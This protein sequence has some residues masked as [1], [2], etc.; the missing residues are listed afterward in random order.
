MKAGDYLDYKNGTNILRMKIVKR[1]AAFATFKIQEI[2]EHG[3]VVKDQQPS[4]VPL[5]RN[6]E[7]FDLFL[8]NRKVLSEEDEITT[9]GGKQYKCHCVNVKYIDP[10]TKKEATGK[11]WFSPDVPLFGLVRWEMGNGALEFL[12]SGNEP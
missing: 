12:K 1:D 4:Q 2:D 8:L 9:A 7:F 10:I 3:T 6:V 11:F 5:Q